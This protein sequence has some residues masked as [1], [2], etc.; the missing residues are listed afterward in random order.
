MRLMKA[1]NQGATEIDSVEFS[2]QGGMP[3]SVNEVKTWI[4]REG[5]TIIEDDLITDLIESVVDEFMRMTNRSLISQ[6]ITAT[7]TSYSRSM[8]LPYGPVDTVT[9]VKLLDGDDEE[10]LATDK[11]Y[12]QGDTLTIQ[13]LSST[14]LE[15]IYTST[16]SF[17]FG[18][19]NAV[20][21]SVLTNYND[22]EDNVLA[23]VTKISNNSRKKA[24]RY[25]RY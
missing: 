8:V 21:Q 23:N 12:L 9:S 22:R 14:G 11:Y 17:P 25:K 6:T 1:Q 16:G 24:L 13:E 20:F 3:V 5:G 10:A 4:R 7:Y 2:N 18:I 15:V 19:R